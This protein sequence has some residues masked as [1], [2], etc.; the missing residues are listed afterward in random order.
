[1]LSKCCNRKIINGAKRGGFY[2][3]C[4]KCGQILEAPTYKISIKTGED[5]FEVYGVFKDKKSA[6]KSVKIKVIK[7]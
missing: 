4:S 1:M 6:L 3:I 2:T 5:E 7:V